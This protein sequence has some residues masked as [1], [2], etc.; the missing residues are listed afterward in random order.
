MV[1]GFTDAFP[2]NSNVTQRYDMSANTW[3]TGPTFTSA[4]ALLALAATSQFLYAIGGDANGGGQVDATALVERLDHTAFP[5]G[6][7]TD[8]ADPLPGPVVVVSAGFCTNAV[9]GGEVWAVDGYIPASAGVQS[10]NQYR[11]SEPCPPG[12]PPAPVVVKTGATLTVEGCGPANGAIDPGE[13]VTVDFALRNIGSADTINVVATLQASGG[14][15][16]ITTSQ[17]Y[18]VLTAGGPPVSRPF[19]FAAAGAC[20]GTLTASL[21]VQDGATNLGTKTFTFTLGTS[22]TTGTATFSNPAPITIPTSVPRRPTPRT[23]RSPA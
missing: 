11:P 17:S 23:S 10:I 1:G 19:T 2:V 7:W 9:S 6:A 16:P 21:A 22:S 15:T 18:G 3:A 14:V 4:R 12:G 20:G 8:T 5:A 13:T